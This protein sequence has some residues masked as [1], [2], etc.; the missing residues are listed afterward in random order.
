MQE[1]QEET[2]EMWVQLLGWEDSPGEGNV[3]PLQYFLPGKYHRQRNLGGYSPW[4]CK[5]L[6]TTDATKHEQACMH[7][8]KLL[9]LNTHPCVEHNTQQQQNTHSPQE[10][11]KRF[12]ESVAHLK[13]SFRKL[14]Y[15]T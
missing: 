11:M 7:A 6:G 4:G 15:Y 9:R 2:Q 10:H 5:E 1:T 12:P 14:G 8:E 13:T 3:N